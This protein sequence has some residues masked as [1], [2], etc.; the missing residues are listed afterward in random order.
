MLANHLHGFGKLSYFPSVIPL[1]FVLDSN[2]KF[3][4]GTHSHFFRWHAAQEGR[5]NNYKRKPGN[6]GVGAWCANKKDSVVN[7]YIQVREEEVRSSVV[8]H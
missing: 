6:R 5:L 7:R 8:G 1:S 4:T 3:N 2:P